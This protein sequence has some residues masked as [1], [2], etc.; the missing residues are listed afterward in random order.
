MK[1]LALL[2]L[3]AVAASAGLALGQTSALP[4]EFKSGPDRIL[5]P[6]GSSAV[7]LVHKALPG[8][9]P[10]LEHFTLE[11]STG[12]KVVQR[13]PTYGY[14]IGAK[15]SPDNKY[16][17]VNNRRGNA[18][19]YVWV[20]SVADGKVLKAP[21]DEMSLVFADRAAR[22]FPDVSTDDLD[23]DVTVATR[24]TKSG[25]VE[26]Q[27]CLPFKNLDDYVILRRALY[28]PVGPDLVQVTEKFEKVRWP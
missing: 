12:G 20:F 27:S 28:R 25:E 26:L 11:L 2:L 23:K 10:N 7:T 9:N 6:D 14:L 22:K 19:D 24:W 5:S 15:W 4:N 16:V 1:T 17:A 8:V 3:A 18:G 21:N 13:C